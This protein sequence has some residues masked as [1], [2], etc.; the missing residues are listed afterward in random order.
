MLL[1]SQ[2]CVGSIFIFQSW[3]FAMLWLISGWNPFLVVNVLIY[4]YFSYSPGLISM[5]FFVFIKNLL[6][7]SGKILLNTAIYFTVYILIKVGTS[8]PWD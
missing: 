3:K 5:Q 7:V 1:T 4:A 6:K 2:K 8:V